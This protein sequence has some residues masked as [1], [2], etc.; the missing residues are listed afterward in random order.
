MKIALIGYGNMGREIAEIVA[1]SKAHSLVS[2]SYK[3]RSG[4]LDI[5]GI[6]KADVVIDFTSA[7]IVLDTIAK[8]L[9]IGTPMVVGTTGWYDNL[10]KVKQLVRKTKTGFIY[11]QNFSI[12]ANM[13]FNIVGYASSL[14]QRYAG[15][16]VFGVET[17]HTRK[18]DSPSGTARK[19]ADVILKH[20]PRKTILQT[21][22][23]DR[24]IQANELHFASVRGGRNFGRHEIV[25]DSPADE[26][27]IE[28]QAWGRRG[29]AEGAV[30][31]AEFV[32]NKKGFYTVDDM[33]PLSPRLRRASRR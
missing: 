20:F 10:A 1:E 14:M 3:T 26:I 5:A 16:D 29:F 18:K 2:V 4:G 17:H 25:F 33:F 32:Q 28:H 7:E 9:K 27:R 24:Q 15:Y 21:E 11:G 22:K 12:G 8:V 6:K 30:L 13:F 23:L 19:L 31:A